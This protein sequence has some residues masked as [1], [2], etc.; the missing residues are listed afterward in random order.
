MIMITMI[1]LAPKNK[2]K[3]LER[4]I[5]NYLEE[6]SFISLLDSKN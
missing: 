6:L 2:N 5:N 4:H 1:I 3:G